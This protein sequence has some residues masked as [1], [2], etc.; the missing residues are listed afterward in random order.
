[1][2]KGPERVTLLYPTDGG[3]L[4][5]EVLSPK[6]GRKRKTKAARRMERARRRR[7]SAGA[8]YWKEMEK[9]HEVANEKNP[10]GSVARRRRNRMTAL[11]RA[12]RAYFR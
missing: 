11:R 8:T 5:Q 9:L 6:G 7:I 12:L 10:W 3:W 1:M 4:A 2:A